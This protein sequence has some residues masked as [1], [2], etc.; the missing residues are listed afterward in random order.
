MQ[1]YMKDKLLSSFID[2]TMCS[3]LL[4]KEHEGECERGE[5]EEGE[6]GV[7]EREIEGGRE[8]SIHLCCRYCFIFQVILP[9]LC[10]TCNYYGPSSQLLSLK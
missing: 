7:G 3:L 9:F 2:I 5:R 8:R 10:S 6:R 4:E 1:H